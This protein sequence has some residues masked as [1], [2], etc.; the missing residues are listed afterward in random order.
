MNILG[1]RAN[2]TIVELTD[3]E[4][5][6]LEMLARKYPDFADGM[7]GMPYIDIQNPIMA[8]MNFSNHLEEI[9]SSFATFEKEYKDVTK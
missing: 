3:N 9:K 1:R 6:A 8:F 7:T 4:L 5:H 2:A